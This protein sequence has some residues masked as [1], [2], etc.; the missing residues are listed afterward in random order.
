VTFGGYH[1]ANEETNELNM[2]NSNYVIVDYMQERAFIKNKRYTHPYLP[3][4]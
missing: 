3:Y 2:Y 1:K 4:E